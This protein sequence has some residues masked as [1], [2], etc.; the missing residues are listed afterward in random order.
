[1]AYT[2][3]K[4]D[5]GDKY[6][7]YHDYHIYRDGRIYSTK[8][9]R[10]LKGT[11]RNQIKQIALTTDGIETIYTLK[12]L[13]YHI[14]I[15][16]NIP[17]I[18]KSNYVFSC[19][20]GDENNISVDNLQ[21]Y[22]RSEY[23]AITSA[24]RV[25]TYDD[26]N[27]YTLANAQTD[28]AIHTDSSGLKYVEYEG[29]YVYDNGTVLKPGPTPTMM[30]GF[31]APEGFKRV[32]LSINGKKKRYAFKKLVAHCFIY[33]AMPP[34]GNTKYKV[35]CNDGNEDNVCADNLTVVFK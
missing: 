20:D 11:T 12:R 30:Y 23:T 24:N 29:Y 27:R 35:L 25:I 21:I 16:N 1:M 15:D 2:I 18:G 14:F 4:D 3:L 31:M 32:E 9:G 7:I 13:I 33:S 17:P 19:I 22:T 8:R 28:Y 6:A 10:F 34:A 5:N 26:N